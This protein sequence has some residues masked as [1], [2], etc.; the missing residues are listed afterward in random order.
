MIVPRAI[1]HQGER[2]SSNNR[3]LVMFMKS[4]LAIGFLLALAIGCQNVAKNGTSLSKSLIP[5]Q[6]RKPKTKYIGD[7]IGFYG[8]NMENVQGIGLVDG[9][10]G[11]GSDPRPSWQRDHLVGELKTRG[12]VG[13]TIQL[14]ADP[15]TSLV[16]LRGFIPPGARRG[17]TFDLEVILEPRSE[18]TSLFDGALMTTK[19]RPNSEFGKKLLE[20]N[21]AAHGSGSVIVEAQFSSRQ[22]KSSWTRGRIPGGG[23]VAE[24]RKV[25]IVIRPEQQSIRSAASIA[26]S[27]NDRFTT[28]TR[29]GRVGVATAKNDTVIE[30]LIPDQYRLNVGRYGQVIAQIA[31]DESAAERVN[32]LEQLEKLAA[33]PANARE[34]S[35]RLEA[36]GRDAIPALQRL[37]RHAEPDVQVCAA[38]AL[39]YQGY[40]DGAAVLRAA[41]ELRPAWR[42]HALTALA[43]LSDRVG[44]ETLADLMH[45]E[46]AETRYGAFRALRFKNSDDRLLRREPVNSD[47]YFHVIPSTASP[48]V[49]ITT[50]G[51]PEI[52]IFGEEQKLNGDFLFVESGLTIKGLGPDQM[53]ITWYRP[54]GTVARRRT[55]SYIADVVRTLAEVR[56]NFNTISRFLLAANQSHALAGRLA[57]D[58]IPTLHRDDETEL[59]MAEA[60]EIASDAG[61]ESPMGGKRERATSPV[62]LGRN[63][64]KM[65]SRN[66]GAR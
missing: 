2:C 34:A 14:L 1:H 15:N 11:T 28:V 49:H 35:L 43:S 65:G 38:L 55:S 9:L 47:F 54:D 21:V 16:V 44:T 58:A 51:R 52:I 46:S 6:N 42:W 25:G 27:I 60:Q 17:D 4:G 10:Q 32:R 39:A 8:F 41:A 62:S 45:V 37:V 50:T 48:L 53:D 19:L 23:V 36:M 22:D 56:G 24:D 66:V 13:N 61:Q 63:S 12:D 57:I 40:T 7:A 30:L 29:S 18:T 31:F 20:G 26:H 5:I 64:A 3:L 33:D 59:V